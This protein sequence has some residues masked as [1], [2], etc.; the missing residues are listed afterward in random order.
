MTSLNGVTL[1]EDLLWS[2]RYSEPSAILSV[3]QTIGGRAIFQQAQFT[4]GKDI[5]LGTVSVSGGFSGLFTKEQIEGIKVL[6]TSGQVV[7]FVYEDFSAL[8]IV[9]PG[10]INV[11][12][13]I[14]RPNSASAD[15]FSGSITLTTF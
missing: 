2:N 7:P 9:V 3:R 11:E 5:I 6:E 14:P 15:Y 10:S 13:L 1:S 8:V 12:P 4:N